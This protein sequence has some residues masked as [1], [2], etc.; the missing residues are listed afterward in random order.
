MT[1]LSINKNQDTGE[2]SLA[3]LVAQSVENIAL[4][5]GELLMHVE[6]SDDD[7]SALLATHRV[8]MRMALKGNLG[9]IESVILNH[10]H[11]ALEEGT[12]TQPWQFEEESFLIT[13]MGAIC[14]PEL[15]VPAIA[16]RLNRTPYSVALKAL[17]LGYQGEGI[18]S[19]CKPN[20]HHL[21]Q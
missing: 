14:A 16:R 3:T 5:I 1:T 11:N 8:C 6:L 2:T 12:N 17:E 18:S 19:L 9:A 13:A 4:D 15:D 20:I 10:L 7:R 21:T